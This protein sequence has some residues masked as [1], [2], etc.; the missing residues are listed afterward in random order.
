MSVLAAKLD[1]SKFDATTLH[2]NDKLARDTGMVDD[3][4]GEKQV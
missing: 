2:S 3:G 4:T 1:M